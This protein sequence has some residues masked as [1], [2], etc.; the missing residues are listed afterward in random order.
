MP[1][2][3]PLTLMLLAFG[4]PAPAFQAAPPRPQF[5][6][7][8]VRIQIIR[9]PI[10]RAPPPPEALSRPLR[11]VTWVERKAARCLPVKRIAAVTV[12]TSDSVDLLLTSG[13]RMRAKLGSDCPAFDFYSGV[14]V[15]PDQ[16]GK[17]CADRDWIR[18]RSGGQCQV[19]S[20]RALEPSR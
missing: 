3:F 19:Q 2:V 10:R 13:R 15:K 11:P 7:G 5:F 9:M 16:D 6:S 12:T 1:Q 14:Y 17:L 8:S 4:L 20:F 18:S